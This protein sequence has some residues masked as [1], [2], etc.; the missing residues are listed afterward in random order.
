[1][2]CSARHVIR[3]PYPKPKLTQIRKQTVIPACDVKPGT[4]AP[5]LIM[6]RITVSI[7]HE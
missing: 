7:M 5:T 3:M 6:I 4:G 1:M 2:R